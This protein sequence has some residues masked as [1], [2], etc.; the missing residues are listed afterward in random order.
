MLVHKLGR[1]L[2]VLP[3]LLLGS[4]CNNTGGEVSELP[5]GQVPGDGSHAALVDFFSEWRE[6][7]NPDFDG[8]VPD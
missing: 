7:E 6:F 4:A 8:Q 2:L 1:Y 3:L 5:E